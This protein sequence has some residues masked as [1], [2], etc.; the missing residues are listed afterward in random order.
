MRSSYRPVEKTAFD[1]ILKD[2][3]TLISSI[4][5]EKKRNEASNQ[6]Q[7]SPYELQKS[8]LSFVLC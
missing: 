4:T 7:L 3:E 5:D 8:N 2:H 6:L 1:M